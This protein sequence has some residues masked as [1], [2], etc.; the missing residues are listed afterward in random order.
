[1]FLCYF[2]GLWVHAL[3]SSLLVRVIDCLGRFVP[4]MTYYLSSGTLNLSKLK[5]KL[6]NSA[7]KKINFR[8]GVTPWRLS[9]GAVP[10]SDATVQSSV[11]LAVYDADVAIVGV[12]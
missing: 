4:E 7:T 12:L 1:M 11:I 10:A 9:P 2:F 8:S 5:P 6:S 3:F